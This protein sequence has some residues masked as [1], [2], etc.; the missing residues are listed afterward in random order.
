M[1]RREERGWFT[2][3]A[4]VVGVGMGDDQIVL[5]G[6]LFFVVVVFATVVVP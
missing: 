2:L 3:G 6:D 1:G 4:V 5:L